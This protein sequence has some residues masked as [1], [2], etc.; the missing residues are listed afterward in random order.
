MTTKN[1]KIGSLLLDQHNPRIPA[2]S[3]QREALQHILDDQ[4]EKLANLAESIVDEGLSPT[5][6]WLVMR[7][8]T[9]K[10]KFVVLEGN[11]RLAAL[12]ILHNPSVLTGLTISNGLQR[13]FERAAG[14]FNANDIE[15]IRC[16]ELTRDEANPWIQRRHIGADQGRGIVDWDG[17]ATARFRGGDPALQALDFVAR[18]GKLTDDQVEL[19]KGRFIT[20][21]RR[22]LETPDVRHELGLDL[23]KSTL[24][25][26][27]PLEEA[28]KGLRRVVLDLAERRY[29]VTQL[30]RKAQMV[31]YITSLNKTD[32]PDLTK[33]ISLV[34]IDEL[35]PT[36][37]SAPRGG[38]GAP[39]LSTPSSA[40]GNA[41]NSGTAGG[42]PRPTPP[43]AGPRS[44]PTVP[45]TSVVAKPYRLR[46]SNAKAAEIYEELKSLVLTKHKHAISVLLRVFLELSVDHHLNAIGSSTTFKD[47]NSGHKVEKK[48]K[49]KVQE[50][51]DDFIA[52]GAPKKEFASIT[53]ALS[54]ATNPLSPDLLHGYVHNR[55]ATPIHGDLTAAW[56]NALP[57]LTRIWA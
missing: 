57:L 49:A 19:L 7:S 43:S 36:H 53:R 52:Q 26:G 45:R 28:I 12:K 35:E 56:D 27:V 32:L 20:T 6:N 4:A 11:R 48:L 37:A 40:G 34:P 38:S 51:I 16:F 47:P 17:Q 39:S 15:P 9:A 14:Q 29:N 10:D 22:L 42:N 3:S 54:V 46:V 25:S 2:V 13:R 50:C 23:K 31:A 8:P 33:T 55:F 21:L 18:H 1:L 24:F 30:K 5:D 44:F 41:P